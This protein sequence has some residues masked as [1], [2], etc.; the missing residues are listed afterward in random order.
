MLLVHNDLD[1]QSHQVL[2]FTNYTKAACSLHAQ[3][4]LQELQ[5]YNSVDEDAI[6]H[7]VHVMHINAAQ[8]GGRYRVHWSHRGGGGGGGGGW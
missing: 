4:Q 2:H 5:I 7:T 8:D 6:I 3:P 1:N